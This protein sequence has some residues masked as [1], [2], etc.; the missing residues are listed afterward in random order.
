MMSK[1]TLHLANLY[2]PKVF[3]ISFQNNV[4]YPS[5]KL[6]KYFSVDITCQVRGNIFIKK[7][8]KSGRLKYFSRI[9][10]TRKE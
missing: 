3:K 5:S 1:F 10:Y 8:I 4:S 9:Y 6:Q 2:L 7:I